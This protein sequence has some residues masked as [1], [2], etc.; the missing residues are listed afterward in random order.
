[1]TV[2]IALLKT[3]PGAFYYKNKVYNKCDPTD[4]VKSSLIGVVP[5]RYETSHF[6]VLMSSE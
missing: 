3:K 1:M 6:M 5:D 4:S 2:A